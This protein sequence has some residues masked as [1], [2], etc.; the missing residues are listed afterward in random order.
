[1][2]KQVSK[3]SITEMRAIV[4]VD[5]SDMDLIRALH[6]AGNDVAAAVNIYFDTPKSNFPLKSKPFS[7]RPAA[8]PPPPPSPRVNLQVRPL[9]E[10]ARPSPSSSR[11]SHTSSP[12]YT[13]ERTNIPAA[14][15]IPPS[16]SPRTHA[17]PPPA[18]KPQPSTERA[19]TEDVHGSGI[20]RNPAST[21][22]DDI[23]VRVLHAKHSLHFKYL[24]NET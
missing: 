10:R 2:A 18:P 15:P 14:R 3:Q 17:R 8:P 16:V 11:P 1:M 4:G 19:C 21:S 20:R 5:P 13:A 6:L 9:Q 12:I 23:N 24:T 22:V 7:R